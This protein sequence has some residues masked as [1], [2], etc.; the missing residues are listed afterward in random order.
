MLMS[1]Y[2]SPMAGGCWFCQTTTG[3][4][5]LDVDTVTGD[6]AWVALLVHEVI[7]A[8][9]EAEERLGKE[10]SHAQ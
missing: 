1:D 10:T 3:E 2:V 6:E 5:V 8:R 7:D 9:S 4:M